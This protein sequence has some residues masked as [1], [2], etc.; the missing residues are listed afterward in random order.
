[1]IHGPNLNLLGKREPE[2][3]GIET[4]DRIDAQLRDLAAELGCEVEA[5]QTNREDEIVSWI[6]ASPG[7]FDGIL[8]NPGAYTHTSIAVRDALVAAAV[9]AVEV[10]LSNPSAREGFRAVSHVEGVVRARI[11]GFGKNSYLLALRGLLA[12]PRDSR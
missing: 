8:L 9:P 12:L 2:I 10:H 1:M 11:A 3:Y 5:R 4:L 6:Q 7:A